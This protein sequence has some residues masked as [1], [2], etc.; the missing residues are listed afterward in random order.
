MYVWERCASRRQRVVRRLPAVV[1]IVTVVPL[2]AVES[3]NL[4]RGHLRASAD[5]LASRIVAGTADAEPHEPLDGGGELVRA[6]ALIRGVDQRPVGVIIAS[7]HLSGETAMHARRITEAYEKYSQ[8]QV[9]KRPLQGVYLSLF[10]MMTLMIRRLIALLGAAAMTAPAFAR[11]SGD[12]RSGFVLVANQQSASASL[13]DLRTDQ[14][15]TIQVGAGPHEAVIAP[16]GRVGVVTI[17]GV[18][19]APGNQLAVIDVPAGTVTKTISLGE[20]TRR[21]YH[22]L[23]MD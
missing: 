6:G 14:A 11:P 23:G 7:D 3:P 17:Y 4:P 15:R 18:G 20:Y 12:L 2:V 9:L 22:L 19:G 8:L 16:S 10:V 1:T 13:I 5:L 21:I